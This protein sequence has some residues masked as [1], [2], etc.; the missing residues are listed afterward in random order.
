M[1]KQRL[2]AYFLLY[3]FIGYTVAIGGWVWEALIF[4]LTEHRF[5]NRGFF[6]G[7]YLPVY[8]AGA[9]LLSVLFY[10]KRIAVIV[11]YT[12]H[13]RTD[14]PQRF[15]HS[16]LYA[17]LRFFIQLKR[18]H[19]AAVRKASGL[20]G[21][22]E[23]S[24]NLCMPATFHPSAKNSRIRRQK[25]F[26]AYMRIFFVSMCGGTL[27]ELTAGWF[28]WHVFHRKYWDYSS[29]PL[30]L[31]GYICLFSSLG[32]GLFGVIWIKWAGPFLIRT[33]ERLSFSVQILL[34]GLADLL[35]VTD[36][37]FSLM[38]PNEGESIT[39]SLVRSGMHAVVYF[40][41]YS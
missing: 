37:V 20:S 19:N 29:Y 6:Y 18:R 14:Y 27:T 11:T 9:V 5:V 32:F 13:N 40:I 8:G 39:F 12:H 4:L 1:N 15:Y 35:F 34:V 7:P 28:L 3:N 21:A 17:K 22:A 23:R 33:W 26:S 41:V 24:A 2:T 36:A 30:N 16:P 25:Q 10:Q 31:A 38:R